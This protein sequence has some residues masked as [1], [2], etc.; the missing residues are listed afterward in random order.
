MR[1]RSDKS[2]G[3]GR[4]G[5]HREKYFE[6]AQAWYLINK[7][8]KTI[9]ELMNLPEE[10]IKRWHQEGHWEEK[11]KLAMTSPR[12]LGEALKGLLREKTQRLLTQGDLKPAEV[13]ELNKIAVLIERLLGEAWD[14]RAAALEVMDRF[15]DYLRH[16]VEN[17]EEIERF[18]GWLLEFYQEL[19]ED[20]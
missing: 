8:I 12:W 17:R 11:K 7:D 13:E 9:A 15:C 2:E 5:L 4:Q 10:T 16:R 18:A 19:E 20:G 14:L 3:G 1:A 6:E